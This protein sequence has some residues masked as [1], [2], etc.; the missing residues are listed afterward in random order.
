MTYDHTYVN[1]IKTVTKEQV[2]A[3]ANVTESQLRHD[4]GSIRAMKHSGFLV[5]PE[6]FAFINHVAAANPKL[7]FGVGPCCRP[8]HSHISKDISIWQEVWAYY[9]DHDM[10]LFRIGY[11]DYG[12]TNTT[13]KYMVC[14]RSIKNKKFS[15]ARSQRYMVLSETRDKIVRETKRLAIPYKP[16]EIAA[17]NFDP[18]YHG[19]SNF[20]S[21][22]THKSGRSF[23]EVK[24]HDDLR[25]EM[26]KL[27]DNGYEFESEPLK[28]AIIKAKQAYEETKSISTSVHAYFVSVF[29]DKFTGKQ[30]CNVL[31]F[32]D[33]QVWT[34]NPI[35]RET[36][37]IA[38]EDMPED[39]I[40]KLAMLNMLNVN[41]YLPEAG[42]KVSDTS[43]WV[44]RT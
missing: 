36:N 41:D 39:L 16:H 12:V 33:V 15:T 5:V 1:N 30:M 3:C 27:L 35:V 37:L 28:Q 25:S 9:D 26:F 32:T 23:R 31:L 6:M 14:A 22:I 2:T 18:I 11:A 34:R 29:E 40:N 21:D 42:V 43:F 8:M 10:A 20:I 19:A 7:R 13:Y 24:E 38:M 4:N 44:V 17:V